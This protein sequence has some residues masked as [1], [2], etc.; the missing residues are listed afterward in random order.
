[1]THKLILFVAL[2]QVAAVYSQETQMLPADVKVERDIAYAQPPNRRQ[3]LDV[4]APAGAKNLPVVVWVHGGG[5]Q[6]ATRA[7]LPISPPP[8]PERA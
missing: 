2:A 7:R 3:M 8:S 1:M 5:W 6:A 4:Y